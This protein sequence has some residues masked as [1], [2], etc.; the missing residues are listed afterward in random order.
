MEAGKDPLAANTVF[1]WV[2]SESHGGLHG[3]RWRKAVA[4]THP[5]AGIDTV[6]NWLCLPE[7]R[8]LS[9]ARVV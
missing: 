7:H 5:K 8:S 6:R 4:Q 1:K 9:D 3:L 2:T